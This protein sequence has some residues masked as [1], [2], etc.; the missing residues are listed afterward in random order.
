M[1]G[2]LTYRSDDDGN[3]FKVEFNV[4]N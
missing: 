1:G 2:E 4:I 3:Y